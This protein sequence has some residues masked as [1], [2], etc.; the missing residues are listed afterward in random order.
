[1]LVKWVPELRHYAPLVP[2]VLVG[3][4]MVS[5]SLYVHMNGEELKKQIGAVAYLEC[6]SKTQQVLM[7][8]VHWQL[9]VG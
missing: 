8:V 7:K 3:T 5:I 6:S 9:C 4:K 2:I 1:M